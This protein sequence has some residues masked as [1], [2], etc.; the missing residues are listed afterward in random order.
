METKTIQVEAY[1]CGKCGT[2]HRD[3]YLA[4]HCC[5]VYHCDICGKELNNYHTRCHECSEKVRFEKANKIKLDEY[6]GKGFY[7]ESFGWNEGYF[8]DIDE[9][10]DYC[11]GEQISVPK[12]VWGCTEVPV[13]IDADDILERATEEAFEDAIDNLEM[14]D[15]LVEFCKKFNEANSDVITYWND[16]KT[17]ILLEKK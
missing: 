12:Y 10:L 4:E 9:L 14:V 1:Q 3:K 2:V 11:D 7:S 13:T 8:F 15:E 6:Q 5:F 16:D 17:A